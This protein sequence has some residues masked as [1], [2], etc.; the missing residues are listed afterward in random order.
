MRTLAVCPVAKG[1]KPLLEG[2]KK[3]GF[4]NRFFYWIYLKVRL[5]L[6]PT[7]RFVLGT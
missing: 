6:S 3:I 7:G 4:L 2:Y 5:I 1:S